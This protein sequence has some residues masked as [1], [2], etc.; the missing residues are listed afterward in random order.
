M[1][2]EMQQGDGAMRAAESVLRTNGG[3][4]VLLRMAA[5]AS[6]GNDAE[7]LGLVTPQFHDIVLAPAVFHKADS[8]KLLL[9]AAGAVDAACGTLGFDA[10]DVLFEAAT[11]IV[12]DDLVYAITDS[13]CSQAMGKA[14]CYWLTLVRPVR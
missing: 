5:P 7:Q 4:S 13:Y 8:V 12:I 6:V 9:V 1:A 10:A 2:G 11:G 3:R 14:Y